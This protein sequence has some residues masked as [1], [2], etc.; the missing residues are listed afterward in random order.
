MDFVGKKG[1]FRLDWDF[2]FF[3]SF[4]KYWPGRSEYFCQ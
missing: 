4:P 3:H 2:E 1:C